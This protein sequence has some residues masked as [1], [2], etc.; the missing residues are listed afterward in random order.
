MTFVQTFG[1]AGAPDPPRLIPSYPAKN[2]MYF[3]GG[4]IRFGKLFMVDADLLT[5]DADESDPFDFYFDYY[6]AQLVAGHHVTLPNYGLVRYLVDFGHL[7]R[8]KT[9]VAGGTGKP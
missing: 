1:A 5:V 9:I 2:Y 4:T 8:A 3:R 6:H 7:G